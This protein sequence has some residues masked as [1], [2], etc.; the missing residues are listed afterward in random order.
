M[1]LDARIPVGAEER[2]WRVARAAFEAREPSP[3]GRN[4]WRPAVALV[5]VGAVAGVL[6]S[7]PGRSVI[8]TIRE[9]V[10]VKK[11]QKEL[12]SLPTPGRLLV[13]SSSGPWIVSADGS[14]RLL[15]RYHEAAWSP[16]GRFVVA[17]RRAALVTM[18][19]QGHQHWT[20]ARRALQSP[21]WGGTRT[22]TRIAYVTDRSLHVVA[23]DGTGDR[24]C[25]PA[26]L[27]V[28]PAWR[29][30]SLRLLAVQ[31]W[32]GSVEVYDVR[33]CHR[34]WRSDSQPGLKKLEWSTDGKLLLAFAPYQ[35]RVYDLRGRVV[36][37]DD[38]S[39]A[40][41]DADAAFL[42]ATH[43][44]VAV[45]LAGSP[46]QEGSTVFRLGDGRPVFSVG[47]ALRQVVPSPDGRW[48]LFTSPAADQ[49]I[50][51]RVE[52]PRK[53]VAVSGITNLLGSR[54]FPQVVGWTGQ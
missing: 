43:T 22:D 29:P 44:V 1:K 3:R 51:V 48:L 34:L 14:R 17:T 23:G 40:T 28:R 45:R 12:F 26:V 4:L 37:Q 20:L 33:A 36:A 42:G 31:G 9:A 27:S 21:A 54:S 2:A 39:D 32:D 24:T 25:L 41:R 49:W 35:L 10:G 13:Q 6:A 53:I 46:G 52:G 18:D 7:P 19:P 30:G 15:G 11:A 47:G 38:P 8:R 50:F 16:F 5:A